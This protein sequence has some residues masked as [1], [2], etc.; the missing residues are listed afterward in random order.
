MQHTQK[1]KNSFSRSLKMCYKAYH[2][3]QYLIEM[4]KIHRRFY[5][6]SNTSVKLVKFL[7]IN[8]KRIKF[9]VLVFRKLY[10]ASAFFLQLVAHGIALI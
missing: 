9:S 7:L 2:S 6:N 8:N 10:Q 5:P 1:S 4:C 3:N